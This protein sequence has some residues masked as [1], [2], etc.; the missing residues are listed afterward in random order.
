M[1]RRPAAASPDFRTALAAHR[2]HKPIL[3][4]GQPHMVRPAVG[5]QLEGMRALVVSAIDLD[6]A[7]ALRAEFAERDFCEQVV[8]GT[9]QF[10]LLYCS[11][12]WASKIAT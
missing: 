3:D 9:L 1:D 10:S 11:P 12:S 5:G 4:V 6:V 2:A 8:I 7:Q